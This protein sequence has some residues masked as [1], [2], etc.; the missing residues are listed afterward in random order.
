M[1]TQL[2]RWESFVDR[3]KQPMTSVILAL[4]RQKKSKA[5]LGNIVVSKDL[6]RGQLMSAPPLK[7]GLRLAGLGFAALCLNGL[8][9]CLPAP[10]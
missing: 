5:C 4:R 6:K 1:G 2:G 10:G 8:P 9:Q 7:G 3:K